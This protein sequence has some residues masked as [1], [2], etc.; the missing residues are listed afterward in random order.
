MTAFRPA[1]GVIRHVNAPTRPRAVVNASVLVTFDA[2]RQS[3]PITPA[4]KTLASLTTAAALCAALAT[5]SLQAQDRQQPQQP[6][7]KRV[8]GEGQPP[9]D[10]KSRESQPRNVQPQGGAPREPQ[11]AGQQG[12][13]DFNTRLIN[14][15]RS[16]L[17]PEQIKHVEE[18][19]QR[20]GPP[21][22]A[23]MQA[24]PQAGPREGE[25]RRPG[26]EGGAPPQGGSR[27]NDRGGSQPGP[28]MQRGQRGDGPQGQPQFQRNFD[29]SHGERPP[30]EGSGRNAGPQN[31]RPSGPQG[32]GDF[33]RGG[34][35]GPDRGGRGDFVPPVERSN[36]PGEFNPPRGGRSDFVPPMKREGGFDEGRARS[37]ESQPGP[38]PN[39][40]PAGAP[41]DNFNP[42]GPR[43]GQ[44][45]GNINPPFRRDGAPQGGPRPEG[46]QPQF[47]R[48]PREGDS[49]PGDR[50]RFNP[51]QD[52]PRGPG[53]GR[54]GENDDSRPR[55]GDG[56]ESRELPRRPEAR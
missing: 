27:F 32:G 39:V 41:R 51:P 14:E 53:P 38:R 22:M 45:P 18:A 31:F 13:G 21:P 15:L 42:P 25:P 16:K 56:G 9:G 46:P 12:P 36:R 3:Q 23:R 40:G 20:V 52:G 28:Q 49:Q 19:L 30:G 26:A 54:G 29:P 50:P 48:E 24:G 47:R 17:T 44:G 8:R 7:P 35:G 4:M 33:N 2:D 10:S 55:R 43:G 37:R 5:A 34:P 6:E 11:A 1:R